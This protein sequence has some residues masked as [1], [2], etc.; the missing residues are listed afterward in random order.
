MLG[1][2][3]CHVPPLPPVSPPDW[4]KDLLLVL[5]CNLLNQVHK[6]KA[7]KDFRLLAVQSKCLTYFTIFFLKHHNSKWVCWLAAGRSESHFPLY[8]EGFTS[9]SVG[10]K[11]FADSLCHMYWSV[12]FCLSTSWM[13][14]AISFISQWCL[15]T[16][17]IWQNTQRKCLQ[18]QC[19]LPEL[20]LVRDI[21][22]VCHLLLCFLSCLWRKKKTTQ[23]SYLYLRQT[24][25]DKKLD[26]VSLCSC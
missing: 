13:L 21:G 3:R 4:V 26:T 9:P 25:V 24:S 10:P 16:R 2:L 20:P 5:F 17:P 22:L 14:T 18:G 19:S 11:T 15:P 23:L 1:V 12:W 6:Q 8:L 7:T